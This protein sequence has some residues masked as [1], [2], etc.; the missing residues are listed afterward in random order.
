MQ[1]AIHLNWSEIRVLGVVGT[2]KETTVDDF[3]LFSFGER[4]DDKYEVQ[5]HT[6]NP[7]NNRSVKSGSPFGFRHKS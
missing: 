1:L 6:V 2:K 4:H 5:V 7:L 3:F